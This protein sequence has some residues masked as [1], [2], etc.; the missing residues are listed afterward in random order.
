MPIVQ[1]NYSLITLRKTDIF[2]YLSE[3]SDKNETGLD[4]D[5]ASDLNDDELMK[6][7]MKEMVKDG[8]AENALGS[9]A[10]DA[11]L[12]AQEA[13]KFQGG[14]KDP[15]H[16]FQTLDVSPMAH[17]SLIGLVSAYYLWNEVKSWFGTGLDKALLLTEI[18]RYALVVDSPL[19]DAMDQVEVG[20]FQGVVSAAVAGA[21]V[22]DIN[23]KFKVNT[24]LRKMA[25][26]SCK[27]RV[28][29]LHDEKVKKE[30]FELR[31]LADARNAHDELI[32]LE[33]K[34][35]LAKHP[36]LGDKEL[37]GLLWRFDTPRITRETDGHDVV[38]ETSE[39]VPPTPPP[40]PNRNK[41]KRAGGIF[42]SVPLL[43]RVPVIGAA[44]RERKPVR[45]GGNNSN[46]ME[47]TWEGK[48]TQ[49]DGLSELS[50]PALETQI[51]E[52]T[53]RRDLLLRRATLA[54]E[55][56]QCVLKKE[57]LA[58]MRLLKTLADEVRDNLDALRFADATNVALKGAAEAQLNN[59]VL[60]DEKNKPKAKDT[61]VEGTS[62]DYFAGG[63]TTHTS[64]TVVSST[65]VD[66]LVDGESGKEVTQEQGVDSSARS[67]EVPPL[68]V[69]NLRSGA[70]LGD[71][72]QVAGDGSNAVLNG[73]IGSGKYSH[74]RRV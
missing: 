51:A 35:L 17:A 23:D 40:A 43:R 5:D 25:L 36:G 15:K 72:T 16:G 14:A 3:V 52:A 13:K 34:K 30:L 62:T 20:T 53:S 8:S 31:V 61:D 12:K 27:R 19:A 74:V 59:R 18:G 55:E 42:R 26:D 6:E 57:Q 64:V 67:F 68:F 49:K 65:P 41:P 11:A 70:T 69:A 48:K 58:Q 37:R 28:R 33:T 50:V 54:S 63:D 71:G 2:F 45:D 38:L 29:E 47:G 22:H 21:A 1:S 9:W 44:T 39:P 32:S 10:R 7:Y 4:D 66:V 46:P 73:F 56:T 24:D 60:F